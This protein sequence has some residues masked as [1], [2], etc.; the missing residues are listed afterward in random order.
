MAKMYAQ[1]EK[2]FQQVKILVDGQDLRSRL[3]THIME[4]P[5]MSSGN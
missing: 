1:E 4:F 3:N 5:C 2:P